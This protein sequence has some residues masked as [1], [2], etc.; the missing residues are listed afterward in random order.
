MDTEAEFIQAMSVL[1]LHPDDI[2]VVKVDVALTHEVGKA[3]RDH[4]LSVMPSS[5]VLVLDK[6]MDIGVVRQQVDGS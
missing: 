6:G 2:L 5:K 1:T 4:V 3:I